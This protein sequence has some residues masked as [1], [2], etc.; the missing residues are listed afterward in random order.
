MSNAIKILMPVV[1]C[2]LSGIL[3]TPILTH[4][5]YK[6]RLWRRVSRVETG[7]QPEFHAIHD[8]ESE[9]RTPRVGGM[10]VWMS[11]IFTLLFIW[12]LGLIFGEKVNDS[13]NFIS[14]EE[15][16]LPFFT[17]IVAS[18]IGLGDDFIQI[19]A[20]GWLSNDPMRLRWIKIGIILAL[21]L[22]IGWWFY[23]K[24]GIDYVFIPNFG[25]LHLGILFLPFFIAIMLAVFSSSVIDGIDGLAGG[26][27]A[28]IFAGYCVIAFGHGQYDLSAF[29][30][31]VTAGILA[32][33][34]FNI[35]PARFYMGETGMIGLTVTISIIAFLTNTVLLLPII[36]FPLFITS[37]SS[38]IQMISRRFWNKKVFLVAPLHHHF[39]AL[40]WPKYKVTMRYWVVSIITTSTGVVIA[41]LQ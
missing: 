5:F 28:S 29:C 24:L 25:F 27:L 34:W 1:L 8:S 21:G 3:L 6:Y 10:I 23:V 15:T 2:F 32:F 41:L 35:P 37:L 40:G 20:K 9:V 19:F 7:T 30:A 38:I 12:I 33:L 11:V 26:V 36:A 22:I 14:R 31:V 16:V 17:L 39:E 4:Y 13:L 18:L